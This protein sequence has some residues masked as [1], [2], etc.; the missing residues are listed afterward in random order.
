MV[1][2]Q[3]DEQV[4]EQVGEQVPHCSRDTGTV[5]FQLNLNKYL[6]KN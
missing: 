4:G 6:I 2:E 3:V 1:E 5:H